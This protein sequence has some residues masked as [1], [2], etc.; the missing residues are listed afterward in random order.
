MRV[1][2]ILAQSLPF[3]KIRGSSLQSQEFFDVTI[4]A[5]LN[6]EV[7]AKVFLK[8][9]YREVLI[10]SSDGSNRVVNP[11]NLFKP[12][13]TLYSAGWSMPGALD[14]SPTA[15]ID[16]GCFFHG[17]NACDAFQFAKMIIGEKKPNLNFS[18]FECLSLFCLH[19]DA[20]QKSLGD[21]G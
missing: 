1:Q 15:P 18:Y 7:T 11:S 10:K 20:S 4:L 2:N 8:I 19:F 5:Y 13:P 16:S 9:N 6:R 14:P 3:V 17:D 12:R 21:C